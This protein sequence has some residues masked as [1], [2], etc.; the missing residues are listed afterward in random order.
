[1]GA[2]GGHPPLPIKTTVINHR[3]AQLRKKM[4]LLR[5]G[6]C[7]TPRV[8]TTD[9]QRVDYSSGKVHPHPL[10]K[11]WRDAAKYGRL[12]GVQARGH[13]AWLCNTHAADSGQSL[14]LPGP[15]VPYL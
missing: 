12:G 6:S 10:K 13:V 1:M 8:S 5:D 2:R 15:Q 3:S 9:K 7:R 4:L 11:Q 14:L